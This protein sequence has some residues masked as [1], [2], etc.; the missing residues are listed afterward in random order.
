MLATR[1]YLEDFN[2]LNVEM[3]TNLELYNRMLAL[4]LD[5]A[6]P[7]AQAAKGA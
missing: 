2:R 3:S 4:Y 5:L 1:K 6:N 7:G